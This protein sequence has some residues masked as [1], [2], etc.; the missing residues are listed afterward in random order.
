VTRARTCVK[1]ATQIVLQCLAPKFVTLALS[2]GLP[3][4]LPAASIP[5]KALSPFHPTA[6]PTT[7]LPTAPISAGE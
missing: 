4:R 2:G 6:P 3:L 1:R 7:S 5:Q